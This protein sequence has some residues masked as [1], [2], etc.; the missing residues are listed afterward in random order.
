MALPYQLTKTLLGALLELEGVTDVTR[1]IF[2]NSTLN[3]KYNIEQ[4]ELPNDVPKIAYF[5]MGI[6]GKKNLDENLSA[7]Y[8]PSPN[9]M[10]LFE[11]IPFRVVPVDVDLTP[12]ERANYRMRV[13]KSVSGQ[14]YW[15]YYLKKLSILDNQV[16]IISINLNDGTET[17]IDT[18]DPNN[19]T[20]VPGNTTAEGAPP[21]THK[22][23]VALDATM[24]LLGSEVV[25]AINILYGGNLLKAHISELGVYSGEDRTITAADGLGGTINYVEAI[26]SQMAYHHCS[27]GNDFSDLTRIENIKLRLSSSKAFIV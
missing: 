2:L 1:R 25:E 7:P 19:L 15:C 6:N 10:D 21:G 3:F 17:E 22:V 5:G 8:I 14:D 18:L 13:L 16:K 9:N 12:S 23:T 24:Q 4:D 11:P 27:L 26:Y 20:P